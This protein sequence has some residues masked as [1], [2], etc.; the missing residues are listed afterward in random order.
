M[1][2]LRAM[3]LTRLLILSAAA[4]LS[5]GALG[6]TRAPGER[7]APAPIAA[8]AGGARGDADVG[9]STPPPGTPPPL[10]VFAPPADAERE[11]SGLARKILT[12]GTGTAHPDLKHSVLDLR[13]AGWERNGRQFEGSSTAGTPGRY[14]PTEMIE[15][16]RHELSLMVE[17]E[18]RRIWVPAA[19]AYAKRTNFA[20]APKGD[21][22]YEVEL[23]RIVP[24]PLPPKDVA[25]PPQDSKASKD[26]SIKTTKSGLVYQVIAKGT[27]KQHPVDETRAEVVYN[28]WT[29]DGHLFQTS[30]VAGDTMTVRVKLLPPGWREAM[31]LMVAGDE[32]RLWLTGK[33]AFG[34]LPPGETPLP[35][36][37]PPGPVVFEVRLV[38]LVE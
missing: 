37:P 12:R 7:G 3:R 16:L 32:W 5:L 22:T 34:D 10:D 15:G 19:L 14:D 27:G 24:L 35:F 6:C 17:G 18:R 1:S 25:G 36:G 8:G 23:V 13:Y 11:P 33:L 2:T 29:P 38:K 28:A 20:N 31:K 4:P 26:K 30:I 21:M 9:M